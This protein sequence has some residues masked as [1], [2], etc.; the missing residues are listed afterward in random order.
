MVSNRALWKFG[1]FRP[2][3]Q[4]S[5]YRLL[6]KNWFYIKIIINY[7]NLESLL[8]IHS[9]IWTKPRNHFENKGVWFF[10]Q[11]CLESEIFRKLRQFWTE[12]QLLGCDKINRGYTILEFVFEY[13]F[14]LALQ[15]W[16]PHKLTKLKSIENLSQNPPPNKLTQPSALVGLSLQT[17]RVSFS[18]NR[19]L[20]CDKSQNLFSTMSDNRFDLRIP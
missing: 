5:A 20:E 14:P 8:R 7:W 9:K 15:V 11:I 1:F 2:W 13:F 10:S 6:T 16:H 17:V 4:G 3:A 18:K 12:T 19:S